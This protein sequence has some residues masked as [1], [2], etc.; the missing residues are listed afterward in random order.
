MTEHRLIAMHKEKINQKT[1]SYVPQWPL[2]RTLLHPSNK[3]GPHNVPQKGSKWKR[4][5]AKDPLHNNGE[6][7]DRQEPQKSHK[8]K[9]TP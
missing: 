3:A 4:K 7:R 9:L 2:N 6:K 1:N 5:D 8:T